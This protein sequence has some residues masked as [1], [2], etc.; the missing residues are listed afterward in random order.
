MSFTLDP[1]QN[2]INTSTDGATTTTNHYSGDSDS[3]AWTSTGATAWIRNLVGIDGGLAATTDNS[4]V[5][6]LQLASPHGDIVATAADTTGAASVS[7]YSEATEYGAP[8]SPSSAYSYGWLGS[9]QRSSNSLAGM[10]LMGVRL[11]DASTGRFLQVD[12]VAGGNE[13]SFV[14]PA[15]PINRVD[16]D[17]RAGWDHH[18]NNG[19]VNVYY[20]RLRSCSPDGAQ[21]YE[22]WFH[23]NGHP[24]GKMDSRNG[25]NG[26]IDVASM[27]VS[28]NQRVIAEAGWSR[29]FGNTGGSWTSPT[30]IER[31]GEKLHFSFRLISYGDG[32]TLYHK[33]VSFVPK[34]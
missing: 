19:A 16:A 29:A 14:Y 11:Y 34:S 4:G 1:D 15:D 25:V 7:S 23:M 5:V 32:R 33:K 31:T 27:H 12:S 3:P 8:R 13:N 22:V 2:R 30:V 10:I 17:G 9:G 26:G 6:T 18:Y 20:K 21:M 24:G 28:Y